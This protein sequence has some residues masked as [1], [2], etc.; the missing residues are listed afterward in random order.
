MGLRDTLVEQI[1]NQ[2]GVCEVVCNHST[3]QDKVETK[4]KENGKKEIELFGGCVEWQHKMEQNGKKEIKLIINQIGGCEVVW[5]GSTTLNKMEQDGKAGIELIR[6]Q[7]GGCE[8]VGNGTKAQK[9][10]FRSGC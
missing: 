8:V 10:D 2:V 5:K 7:V 1:T 6:N 4:Q 9:G 3:K